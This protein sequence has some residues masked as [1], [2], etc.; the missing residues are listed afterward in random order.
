MHVTAV[1]ECESQMEAVQI[2][3]LLGGVASPSTPGYDPARAIFNSSAALSSMI[4]A[5]GSAAVGAA[6]AAIDLSG[7]VARTSP[8]PSTS[9]ASTTPTGPAHLLASGAQRVTLPRSPGIGHLHILSR[10]PRASAHAELHIWPEILARS[11]DG[12]DWELAAAGVSGGASAGIGQSGGE[13]AYGLSVLACTA[14]E[15]VLRLPHKDGYAHRLEAIDPTAAIV[16]GTSGSGHR[17]LAPAV[18]PPSPAQRAAAKL[19]TQTTFG[20]KQSEIDA[21]SASV[22]AATSGGGGATDVF[23]A[24]I[25]Q[26]MAL[27][28]S[29]HRA[30]YRARTNPRLSGP[31]AMVGSL[32]RACNAGS[33]WARYAF[34][35]SD[36]W[37]TVQISR[38]AD[39]DGN[40]T[41][42]IVLSGV[43]RSELPMALAQT[44]GFDAL[45]V[46]ASTTFD[47]YVC[48]VAEQVGGI[49][50]LVPLAADSRRSRRLAYHVPPSV[51]QTAC[52]GTSTHRIVLNPSIIYA[53]AAP[54]SATLDVG[55]GGASFIS[56]LSWKGVAG[57]SS[58]AQDDLKGRPSPPPPPYPFPPPPPPPEPKPPSPTPAPPMS[59]YRL[60]TPDSGAMSSI[61]H[62]KPVSYC[63][64][65]TRTN[66]FCHSASGDLNPWLT[67]RLP[68]PE[69][70]EWVR[71]TNRL[72]NKR[73]RLNPFEI[74][75]G[76]A[77]G[78]VNGTRC[79]DLHSAPS[80]D[81]EPIVVRCNSDAI[82]S[83]V[84]LR[85]PGTRTLNV[86]LMQVYGSASTSPPLPPS[87]PLPSPPPPSPVPSAPPSPAGPPPPPAPPPDVADVLVLDRLYTE[88][89]LSEVEQEDTS[90]LLRVGANYYRHDPRVT[91]LGNTLDSPVAVSSTS[92]NGQSCPTAPKT[93]VNQASCRLV[94]ACSQL[95]YS[96]VTFTLNAENLRKFYTAGGMYVYA[97]S[98]LV[99]SSTDGSRKS[100]CSS[101]GTRWAS[102][103]G[104]CGADATPLD[105]ETKALVEDKIRTSN[106]AANHVVRDIAKVTGSCTTE[107]DGVSVIGSKVEVDGV[108]WQNVHPHHLNVYDATY[109]STVH[110]GN[111][112]FP[113]DANPIR[114]FAKLSTTDD[115][116]RTTLQYPFSSHGMGRWR[117]QRKS[118]KFRFIGKLGDIVD[119]QNLPPSVQS[120]ATAAA[121]GSVASHVAGDVETCGSAGEVRALISLLLPC[122]LHTLR[123]PLTCSA[124]W[125]V[126]R[127]PTRRLKGIGTRCRCLLGST[128]APIRRG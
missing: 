52:G 49:V 10:V 74:W 35:T 66:R 92:L 61:G 116:V 76:H 37:S 2:A 12:E 32:R 45:G 53:G 18:A 11:Y 51:A 22:E 17:Q 96:S 43:L 107:L 48:L 125:L 7:P 6:I 119:F 14:A 89:N 41:L 88:C 27:S 59:E 85:L 50:R 68:A 82:G 100:P 70:V 114:A 120:E 55:D 42:R 105:N 20:P 90:T 94:A 99:I 25:E 102:L 84:T 57:Y 80:R 79:G 128:R 38:A 111:A 28:P 69:R 33:R 78:G 36:V 30:Y 75:V 77:D 56:F 60:I 97:M 29:L 115:S 72:G 40:P 64:F 65:D 73:S 101:S 123:A 16:G 58:T 67:I 83:H 103:S 108:C 126:H 26:Q 121:F 117:D 13:G 71:I 15:C 112:A 19:L 47:G 44:R 21:L 91:T 54:T 122:T 104:P 110:D 34:A 31:R 124:A 62:D 98:G 93:F 23:A 106:D 8:A 109:W 95:V 5:A 87:P 127:S 86:A 113:T 46:N 24:W 3:Q 118:P 1:I 4:V 39:A 63:V 81:Y 9:V